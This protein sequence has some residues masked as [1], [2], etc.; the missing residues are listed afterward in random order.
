[1]SFGAMWGRRTWIGLAVAVGV[2]LL[3]I[4]LGALLLVKGVLPEDAAV[5]WVCAGAAAAAVLGGCTAGK[6]GVR[7]RALI[8]AVLLYGILWCVGLASSEPLDFGNCGLWITAAVLGGGLAACLLCRNGK[9]KKK[10]RRAGGA[11]GKRR[12]RAVT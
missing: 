12:R 3:W 10:R 4:M 7:V 9:G 6:G 11:A 1:M 2:L 8:V 5:F